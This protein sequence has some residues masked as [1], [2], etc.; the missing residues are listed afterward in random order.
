MNAP[1]ED[2]AEKTIMNEK[3]KTRTGKFLNL[4]LRHEYETA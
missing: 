2:A 1:G 3:Q 4:I